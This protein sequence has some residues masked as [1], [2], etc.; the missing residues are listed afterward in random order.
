MLIL[1]AD[2]P[3]NPGW[4]TSLSAPGASNESRSSA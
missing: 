1:N 4:S 3:E 2:F